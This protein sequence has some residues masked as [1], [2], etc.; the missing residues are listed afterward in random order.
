M[1]TLFIA[2]FLFCLVAIS[3][4]VI[5]FVAVVKSAKQKGRSSGLWF[6]L[7]ICFTPVFCL[8]ILTCIGMTDEKRRELVIEEEKL[9]LKV[10]AGIQNL[11]MTN[12]TKESIEAEDGGTLKIEKGMGSV[13][14]GVLVLF[15]TIGIAFCIGGK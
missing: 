1:G 3:V 11:E 15:L 13:I 12:I 6:F 10:N 8:F 5:L 4:Y 7:S 14:M 2:W 9:R